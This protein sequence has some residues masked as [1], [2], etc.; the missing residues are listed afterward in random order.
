MR[1]LSRIRVGRLR[2]PSP[3]T[4]LGLLALMVALGGN[5]SALPGVGQVLSDDIRN[6]H[7]RK[8]D[9]GARAVGASEIR[10]G[11]AR[12]SEIATDAVRSSEIA[13]DAV[14][15]AELASGSVAA[16]EL[17]TGSVGD[18]ELG[19][20]V[21]RDGPDT[22]IVD[23]A[24]DGDWTSAQ[25]GPAQCQAGEKLIGGTMEWTTDGGVNGDLSIIKMFP[26]F[27]V[28]TWTAVGG[29]DEGTSETFHPVAF[30]LQ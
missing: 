27:S 14:G 13:T 19:T 5:A 6:G 22:T 20:I 21:E 26:N 29:N 24:N 2:R 3:G 17:A 11:A 18:E 1:Y 7:V 8:R 28:N 9:I 10:S 12:S 16:D 15:S 4:V 25:S 23:A 30:C